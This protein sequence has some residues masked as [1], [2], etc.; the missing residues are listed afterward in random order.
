MTEREASPDTASAA[1]SPWL[2]A[3][4]CLALAL[5]AALPYGEVGSFEFITFDDPGYVL[6]NRIVNGGFHVTAIR[7]AFTES[8]M[9]NWHPLTWI[10]H[11]LD[12]EIFGRDP[13]GHH[14]MNVVL[15]A[16]NA[17]LLLLALKALT[18][19]LWRSLLVAAFFALHPLRVE[20]VAWVS[21]RKDVLSGT[22]WMLTLLAYAAHARRPTRTAYCTLLITF[23]LGLLAKPM[24]VTLP[25]VLLLLDY[26]P[27]RRTT[28]LTGLNSFP[29]TPLRTR[30]YEKSWMFLLGGLVAV[31][32][33][34]AQQSGEAIKTTQVTEWGARFLNAFSAATGYIANSLWPADLAFFY[35]HPAQIGQPYESQG[36]IS[37]GVLLIITYLASRLRSGHPWLLVGWLWFL[38]TLVPV[39]G[40]LQ[41]GEQSMAD[42]YTYLPSIGLGIMF[43]WELGDLVKR[44]VA[45]KALM[46]G[47]CAVALVAL[48]LATCKQV[49]TWKNS[50]TLYLHALEVTD[51]NYNAHSLLGS[52]YLDQDKLDL[53]EEHLLAALN[54]ENRLDRAHYNL[55]NVEAK[56]GNTD[57]AEDRFRTAL[58]LRPAN[59]EAHNN[60]GILLAN[61]GQFAEA[62]EHLQ[63]AVELDAS[64]EPAQRN[65]SSVRS[66]RDRRRRAKS[67]ARE[68]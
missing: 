57:R 53:A 45:P 54:I 24:L 21:E 23:T 6:N 50:E 39:I 27:L 7:E 56:R 38:G 62:L 58:L 28:S 34:V 64:N 30:L 60:L 65:L 42:R 10:S 37:L 67:G 5:A 14:A 61:A 17:V 41:V 36:F 63:R 2:L 26:W 15:H 40:I 19:S 22:F 20:S 3:T 18:G 44:Q 66:M 47:A 11:M 1:T 9:A 29:R 32:T 13:G 55:G 12:Y 4:L 43:A 35:P 49:A 31:A 8:A 33:L 59:S 48:G 68:R 46:V 16:L 52:L 51:N 25:C